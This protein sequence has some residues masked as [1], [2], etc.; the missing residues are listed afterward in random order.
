METSEAIALAIIALKQYEAESLKLASC[1]DENTQ[2][3][4]WYVDQAD[5][6]N[7][8]ILSLSRIKFTN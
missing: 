6:Y 8:A 4:K 7:E 2:W 5:K 3:H 1:V